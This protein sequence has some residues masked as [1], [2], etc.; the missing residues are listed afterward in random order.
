[1]FYALGSLE[2]LTSWRAYEPVDPNDV[3]IVGTAAAFID[4]KRAMQAVVDTL[5]GGTVLALTDRRSALDQSNADAIRGAT[6]VICVDGS[7]L[8][9]RTIWRNSP[10]GDALC[11][12]SV[13][14]I[15]SVSS[16]F[17]T[18]MIDPRGGAPTT[19]LNRFDDVV[20]AMPSEATQRERTQQL[21][22]P[23]L[24]FVELTP[25]AV[26]GYDESWRVIDG[27]VVVTRAGA[28]AQ[29]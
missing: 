6:F 24:L 12:A 13:V 29:L 9:A 7:A 22:G 19:G 5:G 3:V 23:Q 26:L 8:H 20:L 2:A 10:V 1:M 15:G 4:A 21:V 14:A 17:G 25:T 11:E 16:V 27:D 28:P 18:V